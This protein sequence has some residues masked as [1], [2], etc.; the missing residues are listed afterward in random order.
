MIH[1]ANKCKMKT[2][3]ERGI[4]LNHYETLQG[5]QSEVPDSLG[6]FRRLFPNCVGSVACVWRA[7]LPP[8][9]FQGP[10]ISHTHLPSDNIS[11]VG[12]V[13]M[14]AKLQTR[15]AASET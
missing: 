3:T 8:T 7:L 13:L 2:L 4:P 11:I 1:T 15:L 12:A 10:S 6:R 5:I 9:L 14:E